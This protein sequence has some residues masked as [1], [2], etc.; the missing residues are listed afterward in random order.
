VPRPRLPSTSRLPECEKDCI[1]FGHVLLCPLHP[2]HGY[3][4]DLISN[5]MDVAVPCIDQVGA[6]IRSGTAISFISILC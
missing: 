4:Q 2:A 5:N 6:S 3:Q 1:V